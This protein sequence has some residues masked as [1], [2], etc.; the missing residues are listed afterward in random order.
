[1]P[2][3]NIALLI[4]Y[5]NSER[6]FANHLFQ[7]GERPKCDMTR[8]FSSAMY[9]HSTMYSICSVKSISER[10]VKHCSVASLTDNYKDDIPLYIALIAGL[11]SVKSKDK[12]DSSSSL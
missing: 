1:M 11:K 4:L 6:K 9:K 3:I 5:G 12:L 7:H 8:G 2:L 10:M